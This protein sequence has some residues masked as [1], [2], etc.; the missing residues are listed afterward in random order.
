MPYSSVMMTCYFTC[1]MT[2][3]FL[4]DVKL[5]RITWNSWNELGVGLFAC[6]LA[7]VKKVKHL[8]CQSPSLLRAY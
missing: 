4:R 3:I 2:P 6:M 1:S 8:S 7:K 5:V